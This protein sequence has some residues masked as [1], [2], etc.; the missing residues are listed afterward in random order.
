MQREERAYDA[1]CYADS[2]SGLLNAR[3]Q[4]ATALVYCRGQYSLDGCHHGK[5]VTVMRYKPLRAQPSWWGCNGRALQ[6]V[7]SLELERLNLDVS[8]FIHDVDYHVSATLALPRHHD[9]V[10]SCLAC[11]RGNGGGLKRNG[12]GLKRCHPSPRARLAA[13]ARACGLYSPS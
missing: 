13:A 6:A 2:S 12:G 1:K 3:M 11:W 7:T 8:R 5:A 9:E 10:S 4:N